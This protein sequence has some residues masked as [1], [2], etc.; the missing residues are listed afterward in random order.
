MLTTFANNHQ[1]GESRFS[2]GQIKW[3]KQ[4]KKII[5]LKITLCKQEDWQKKKVKV[6][7]TCL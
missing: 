2:V 7:A 5:S 3:K 6:G 1:L 4:R